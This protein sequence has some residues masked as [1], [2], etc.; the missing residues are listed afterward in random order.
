MGRQA[1]SSC[2][3]LESRCCL[4]PT[5]LV[6]KQGGAGPSSA[7]LPP[8]PLQLQLLHQVAH[9]IVQ[10]VANPWRQPPEGSARR[11]RRQGEGTSHRRRQADGHTLWKAGESCCAGQA[12]V[13]RRHPHGCCRPWSRPS[14]CRR[15]SSCCRL[16]LV[17]CRGTGGNGRATSR[18]AL[19]LPLPHEGL[20][21]R[22]PCRCLLLRPMLRCG[23]LILSPPPRRSRLRPCLLLLLLELLYVC[24]GI[25]L[26]LRRHGWR[27]VEP[28]LVRRL[29]RAVVIRPCIRE[30]GEPRESECCL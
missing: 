24:S 21:K 18:P 14:C 29:A 11:R 2:D 12:S 3:G 5:G 15:R 19:L 10:M 25:L 16:L 6:Y 9:H 7:I 13:Q 23:R 1:A 20:H 8:L 30:V 4:L 17:A 27:R 22:S 28:L 26:Q